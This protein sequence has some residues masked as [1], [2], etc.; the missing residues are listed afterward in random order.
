M[1]QVILIRKEEPRFQEGGK[2][3]WDTVSNFAKYTWVRQG[4]KIS[5]AF[6]HFLWSKY[7]A[8][9]AGQKNMP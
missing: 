1:H 7:I 4:K 2:Q 3:S 6:H 5:D 8:A 9:D